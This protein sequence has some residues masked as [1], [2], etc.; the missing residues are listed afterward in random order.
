MGI[1]AAKPEENSCLGTSL[2]NNFFSKKWCIFNHYLF[3]PY[4]S[5]CWGFSSFSFPLLFYILEAQ[6]L[7]NAGM[8]WKEFRD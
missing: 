3:N 1:K 5:S 6:C 2:K 4:L 7:E 8:L